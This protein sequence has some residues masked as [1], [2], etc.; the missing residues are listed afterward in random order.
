MVVPS[1]EPA[2]CEPHHTRERG[3][4]HPG[5][6]EAFKVPGDDAPVILS[7]LML[8]D[9]RP[10]ARVSCDATFDDHL[11]RSFTLLPGVV[12][13]LSKIAHFA[14]NTII[15]FRLERPCA[16]VLAK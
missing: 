6:S 1:P 9:S 13:A 3:Q 14:P 16:V 5:T 7:S 11:C 10:S 15:V 8:Y 12:G 2:E 4:S